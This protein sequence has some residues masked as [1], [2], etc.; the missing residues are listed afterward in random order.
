MKKITKGLR[1]KHKVYF[2]KD[3]IRNPFYFGLTFIQSFF[4]FFKE[5][6][7]V[8]ITTGGGIAIPIS[9]L[10]KLMRKKIG[11]IESSSRV[12]TPSLTGKILYPIADLFLV[13]WKCL[14]KRYGKKARYE[15]RVF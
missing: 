15:G 9:F 10:G 5:K 3:P 11:F 13:Q 14:L 8:I 1:K 6:P 4:I 12:K 7:D 2:I